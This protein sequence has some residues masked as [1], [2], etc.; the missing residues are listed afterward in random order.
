MGEFD[1]EWESILGDRDDDRLAG[2]G[3]N[4]RGGGVDDRLAG[5]SDN[6]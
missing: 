2:G 1:A 3:D 5:G 6:R 4:R